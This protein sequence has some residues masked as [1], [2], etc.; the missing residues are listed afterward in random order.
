MA[1]ATLSAPRLQTLDEMIQNGV[2]FEA[3]E[4]A[5]FG[6]TIRRHIATGHDYLRDRLANGTLLDDGSRGYAPRRV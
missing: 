3:H 2:D 1:D 4:H 5:S 6:H